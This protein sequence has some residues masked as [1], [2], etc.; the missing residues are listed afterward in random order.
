VVGTIIAFWLDFLISQ[1][2]ERYN[3]VIGVIFVL[4][5]LFLPGGVLSIADSLGQGA[6]PPFLHRFLSRKNADK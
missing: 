6:T 5:V 1:A 3:T 4:T 2:T